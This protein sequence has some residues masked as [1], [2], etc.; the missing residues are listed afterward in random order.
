MGSKRS[1]IFY[2]DWKQ[3]LSRMKNDE[4]R[5]RF[6]MALIDYASEGTIYSPDDPV[7]QLVFDI[8]KS[9]IDRDKDKYNLRCQ[10]NA[11]NA[12]K[13]WNDDLMHTITCVCLVQKE[14][15]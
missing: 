12:R 9:A 1:F 6:M 8:C 15:D 13:R 11:E 2:Y 5:G 7:E 4:A 10:V 3:Y 14:N